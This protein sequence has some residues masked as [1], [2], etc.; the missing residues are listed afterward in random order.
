MRIKWLGS[1][2]HRVMVAGFAATSIVAMNFL[3]SSCA[4]PLTQEGRIGADDGADSCRAYVVALDST[5]NFFAE[6]ML[7]G[8]AMGAAAGAL[9][10]ALLSGGNDVGKKMAI[11]AVAGGVAGAAAGYWKHKQDQSKDQAILAVNNDLKQEIGQ[12]DK[13]N[14]AFGQ[15]LSCRKQQFAAIKTNVKKKVIT[16]EQASAQWTA[17]QGYLAR[18]I[19]LA[20]MIDENMAKRG[21]NYA[22]ADKEVNGSD[23]SAMES[24]DEVAPSGKKAKTAKKKHVAKVKRDPQKQELATLTA[25]RQHKADE[26]HSN[27][28]V[29][30]DLSKA[31]PGFTSM[32]NLSTDRLLFG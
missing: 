26:F 22:Y 14:Q 32:W 27:V 5:G 1:R 15:L 24:T 13:A 10:G 4:V 23:Q 6:D 31:D 16:I 17:Q 20:S 29:A 30:K 2:G 18:D 12:V 19:K 25:T 3:L 11:G 7:K 21:E 9:A 28:Q 8:A